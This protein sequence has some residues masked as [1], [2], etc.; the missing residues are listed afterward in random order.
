MTKLTPR[1]RSALFAILLIGCGTADTAEPRRWPARRRSRRQHRLP[2]AAP[3]TAT[4]RRQRAGAATLEFKKRIEATEDPQRAEGKVPNLK[5]TDDPKEISDRQ[6][7]L[8][9]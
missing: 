6:T 7:A 5:K 4:T 2:T 9:R 8:A 1:R 3:A